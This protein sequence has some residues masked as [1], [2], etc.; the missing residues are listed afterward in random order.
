MNIKA[1]V[2]C[3]VNVASRIGRRNIRLYIGVHK[4]KGFD[5]SYKGSGSALCNAF[6]KYGK[7]NFH[8]YMIKAFESFEE[9]L[10]Y[11]AY[12]IMKFDAAN[13]D[14]LMFYNLSEGGRGPKGCTY[15]WMENPD[16]G[17]RVHAKPSEIEY[18]EEHGFVARYHH[19]TRMYRDENDQEGILVEYEKVKE[20]E[21]LG[22]HTQISSYNRVWM[23]DGKHNIYPKKDEAPR[24]ELE[25]YTYGMISAGP[26]GRI[27]VHNSRT[28][29]HLLIY[30]ED[31]DE[32]IIQGYEPGLGIDPHEGKKMVTDGSVEFYVDEE[33]IPEYL[34]NGYRLGHIKSYKMTNGTEIVTVPYEDE[35]RYESMG[36]KR[37]VAETHDNRGRIAVTNGVVDKKIH[38]EDMPIYAEEGFYPGSVQ[39]YASF[40]GYLWYTN[41]LDN[42][43]VGPEGDP[44]PL[45]DAGYTRGHMSRERIEENKKVYNKLREVL[46]NL[47]NDILARRSLETIR[48]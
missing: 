48:S 7:E 15:T 2:Y 36:Y 3:T 31:M 43:R 41:G 6:N 37:I 16:T 38:P 39:K 18:Y 27:W 44:Q 24:R 22:Y 1:Y 17:Q 28:G 29:D 5:K 23:N 42:K 4:H 14:N 25:G 10:E 32:L 12:L 33:L 9:A 45:I 11:E 13:Y 34:K 21:A 20:Y 30:P 46:E 35:L 47:T 26:L 40:K 19:M 8:T